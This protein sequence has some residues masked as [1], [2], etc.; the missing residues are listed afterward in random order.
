[1]V[2][3]DVLAAKLAE[4]SL[5]V[6]RVRG[7][8]PATADELGATADALD[9]VAFRPE[10]DDVAWARPRIRGARAQCSAPAS[11]ISGSSSPLSYMSRTMSQP[12]TN[13][14]FT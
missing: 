13:F 3:R 11:R 9:L 8:C 14:P 4:L 2:D 10:R 7:H 5:R 6:A 12:P 1:M